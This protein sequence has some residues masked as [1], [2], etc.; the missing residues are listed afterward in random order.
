MIENMKFP[1]VNYGQNEL[2]TYIFKTIS[3][4]KVSTYC[5]SEGGNDFEN[6]V[7]KNR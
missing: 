6:S 3:Y 7:R 5:Y 2:V 4:L 1:S